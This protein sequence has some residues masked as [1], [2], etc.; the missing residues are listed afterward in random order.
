MP[1][2]LSKRLKEQATLYVMDI[3]S[4]EEKATF[5]QE[6][7]RSDQLETYLNELLSTLRVVSHLPSKQPSETLLQRQRNLLRGRTDIMKAEPFYSL[8]I[9]KI[10][11][12]TWSISD[13]FFFTGRPAVAAVTFLLIGLIVGRFLLFPTTTPDLPTTPELTVEERIQ[14]IIKAGQLAETQI[15]PLSNGTN[16]VAF[17][18]KAEDEIEYAGGLKDETVRELLSY[19]LLNE[20]NPGKRLK[21]LKLMSDLTPDE[22]MK[23]VLVAAL[24]SDEN[25]GVRLR[26]IKSLATYPVDKTV[27]DACTKILLEEQNTAIRMEALNILAR[28]PDEKLIPVLQVVSR[29]DSNEFI[30][31]EAAAILDE[32]GDSINSQ[33]IEE[34]Q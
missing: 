27:Q 22:E 3:L 34:I 8:F 6:L 13:F 17:R 29:L 19:L 31:E 5:E 26:A 18:L 23:M 24:L 32:L 20:A 4:P 33:S 25:P 30:R 21:S 12:I 7:E 28:N 15:Q 11:D 1:D 10:K 16:T 9:R 14:Q 2:K